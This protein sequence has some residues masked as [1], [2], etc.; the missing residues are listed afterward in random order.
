MHRRLYPPARFPDG[1]FELAEGLN[2]VGVALTFLGRLEEALEHHQQ[3]LA[4]RRKL[5]SPAQ[6]PDGHPELALSLNNVGMALLVTGRPVAAAEILAEALRMQRGLIDQLALGASEGEA[7]AFARRILSSL[8]NYLSATAQRPGA[9]ATAYAQVW[10]QRS[11]LSRV[12]Q[13]RHLAALAAAPA[14]SEVGRLFERQQLVRQ[15]LAAQ[16]LAP[17]PMAPEALRRRD[18]RVNDLTEAKQR[19]ER[20]LIALLPE[21]DRQRRLARLGPDDLARALPQGA[22]FVDLLRY[23]PT[24]LEPNKAGR[25]GTKD[26]AHYVAFVV[27]H[28]RP[29]QRVE[30]KEAEAIEEALAEWRHLIEQRREL[31]QPAVTT[32]LRRLLWEPLRDALPRPTRLVF[33]A[34]DAALTRL[35]WAALPGEQPGTVLLEDHAVAV[36]PHGPFLVEALTSPVRFGKGRAGALALGS[37]AYS[38]MPAPLEAPPAVRGSEPTGAAATWIDLPGSASELKLLGQL[39]GDKVTCLEGN[40]ADV[41]RLL[42]ALPR[43]SLAHLS[44]HGFFNDKLFQQERQRSRFQADALLHSHEVFRDALITMGPLNPLSYTGLVLA[45]ANKPERAGVH[46]GILTGEALLTLDLR[47]LEL[48]VLSACQTGLGDVANGECVHN[49]QQAFH[50]AGCPN[51]IAALWSV[52][53][54]ATAAL[55]GL[56]YQ[57]LLVDKLPPLEALRAAQLYLYRHPEEIPDLVQRLDRGAPL[58]AQGIKV[59]QPYTKPTVPPMSERKRG[60]ARDWAAFVLSGVGR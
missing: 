21:A 11:A 26:R 55:M 59:S 44:T 42:Q 31:D 57:A 45:G 58:L 20:E 34:P 22:A 32:R 8:H 40:R 17:L 4:M 6:F 35:P 38:D 25:P 41:G 7:L 50:S 33:V 36:V 39:Y 52:P 13:R 16:L 5:F 19:L 18:R 12:L 27:S 9:D 48:C 60:S 56:F 2:N 30:L 10:G 24:E 43:A 47:K 46:G 23:H 1:H 29:I 49:L 54:E 51:V 3:V 15:E 53:D 28:G 14:N 37:V